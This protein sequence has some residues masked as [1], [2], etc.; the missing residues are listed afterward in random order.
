MSLKWVGF[1]FGCGVLQLQRQCARALLAL[2]ERQ[3]S[4]VTDRQ[5]GRQAGQEDRQLVSQ[6]EWRV[7]ASM[8]E[9]PLHVWVSGTWLTAGRGGRE[10]EHG[11]GWWLLCES[12]EASCLI[13]STYSMCAHSEI[14]RRTKKPSAQLKSW[15]TAMARSSKL[16]RTKGSVVQTDEQVKLYP[17]TLICKSVF[18]QT[19]IN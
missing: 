17:A 7:D 3:S 2:G 13:E 16:T 10:R 11:H 4:E 19:G 14:M 18:H 6:W 15:Q 9:A 5:T 8:R 1:D 12:W